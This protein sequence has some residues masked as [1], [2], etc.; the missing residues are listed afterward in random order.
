[1]ALRLQSVP[2]R[3]GIA[4]VRLSFGV[5]A[6]RPMAFSLLFSGYLMV[7]LLVSVL[8]PLVGSIVMLMCVPLLGLAYMRATQATLRQEPMPWAGF[9]EPVVAASP[10]RRSLLKLCAL[11]AAA[12]TVL[13]LLLTLMAGEALRHW[14]ELMM[15]SKATAEQLEAAATDHRIRNGVWLFLGGSALIA[16]PFWHAPALVQWCRQ[17][18]AQALFSSTLACWRNKGAFLIYGLA[19]FVVISVFGLVLNLVFTLIGAP[20]MALVATMPATLMFTTVFY[21]SMYF[22]FVDSFVLTED[23]AG[24]EAVTPSSS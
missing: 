17:G 19:W 9:L 15:D 13:M 10:Q 21:I 6:R 16:I 23:P 14:Q 2:A 7:A 18:V 12:M 11:F 4:W 3:Q 5:F 20:Q 8:L 22:T 1:M 24:G